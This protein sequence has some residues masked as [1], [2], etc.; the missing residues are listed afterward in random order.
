M[1]ESEKLALGVSTATL[2]S[3]SYTCSIPDRPEPS[4]VIAK[5][6]PNESAAIVEARKIGVVQAATIQY[7]KDNP[8]SIL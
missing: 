5:G 8:G 7:I 4:H 1:N 2:L 3:G 6:C